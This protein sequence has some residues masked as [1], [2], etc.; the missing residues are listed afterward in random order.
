MRHPV[1][2]HLDSN[3]PPVALNRGLN[4]LL[5][6]DLSVVD[7]WSLPSMPGF[8]ARKTALG[9]TYTYR[10]SQ[11][12]YKDPFLARYSWHVTQ[13][14][15]AQAMTQASLALLGEHDFSAFRAADCDARSPLRRV[16]SIIV[17]NDQ[18]EIKIT[19][20]GN[21]FLRNMVRIIAGTLVDVGRGKHDPGW[22]GDLILKR[23]RTQAGRTAPPWG[24]CL[25]DV[26][27]PP[28]IVAFSPVG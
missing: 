13:H 20:N 26:D 21:A 6:H 27:Y 10:I 22:V 2:V 3:L 1:A 8:S 7:V 9:K 15:D 18:K 17:E 16:F 4:S 14:L 28:E 23:D 11:L 24:L 12:P 5:P 25:A 19:I